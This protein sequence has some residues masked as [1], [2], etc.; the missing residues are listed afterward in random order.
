MNV[1]SLVFLSDYSTHHPYQ[2]CITQSC[3]PFLPFPLLLSSPPSFPPKDMLPSSDQPVAA[4]DP[5]DCD[6]VCQCAATTWDGG[7]GKAAPQ[8]RGSGLG[9]HAPLQLQTVS[10][11][12]QIASKRQTSY[13][14]CNKIRH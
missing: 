10:Q 12:D 13:V 1:G 9:H 6:P 11:Q 4:G 3:P 8:H 14:Q 2:P 5:A 7:E